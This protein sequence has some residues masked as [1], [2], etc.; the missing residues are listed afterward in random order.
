MG[1]RDTFGRT[2]TLVLQSSMLL[3]GRA[4]SCRPSIEM[5]LGYGSPYS[6]A[7]YGHD[8]VQ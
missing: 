4:V 6:R 2:R 3:T 7:G 8:S 1:A 5:T